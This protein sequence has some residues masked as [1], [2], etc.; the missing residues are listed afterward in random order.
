MNWLLGIL[1]IDPASL[2]GKLLSLL[3]YILVVGLLVGTYYLGKH[4]GVIQCNAAQLELVI[5][6][7][8][9]KITEIKKQYAA[10]GVELAKL[11]A[12]EDAIDTTNHDAKDHI[13]IITKFQKC[14]QGQDLI[15]QLNRV[16]N[17]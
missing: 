2:I 9:A 5:K 17:E 6:A 7:K 3:P 11:K 1:G 14:D 8:D 13:H 15:D 10:Q 12:K 16:R 4:N